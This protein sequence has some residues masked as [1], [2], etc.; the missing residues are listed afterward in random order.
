MSKS[1]G[2]IGNGF[3]GDAV[4]HGI[5]AVGYVPLIY[6]ANTNRSEV[7]YEVAACC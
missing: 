5:K 1:V 4:A 6:D 7:D 3:V 2:I